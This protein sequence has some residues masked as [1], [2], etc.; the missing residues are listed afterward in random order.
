MFGNRRLMKHVVANLK[1]PDFDFCELQC[2]YQPNCVSINFKVIPDSEGIH[3]CELNS[4]THRSHGNELSNRDGYVYKGADVSN[5]N[6]LLSFTK[7]K[8]KSPTIE[9]VLWH[10]LTSDNAINATFGFV[11]SWW[12]L[13]SHLSWRL[14]WLR[15]CVKFMPGSVSSW[16]KIRAEVSI[17]VYVKVRVQ[18]LNIV[19]VTITLCSVL[20]S[21]RIR[22]KLWIGGLM[23][24]N[25]L[26]NNKKNINFFYGLMLKK[27][28]AFVSNSRSC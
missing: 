9:S 4:A 18:A 28:F 7:I 8:K 2:Y 11:Y 3:E 26:K 13:A 17:L 21:S 19:H 6:I 20:Y 27:W 23:F 12:S 10:S 1:V 25:Y 5:R 15:V 14:L 22:A 24:K 16:W